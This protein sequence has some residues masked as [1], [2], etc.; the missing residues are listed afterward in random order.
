MK[1]CYVDILAAKTAR[2][3]E[4]N[5]GGM[6][7][8]EPIA[9]SGR[10]PAWELAA[11]IDFQGQGGQ[12]EDIKG[13]LICGSECREDLEPLLKSVCARLGCGEELLAT[14]QG[15]ANILSEFLNIAIGVAGADWEK[16]GFAMDFSPPVNLSGQPPQISDEAEVFQLL[17][18]GDN[19]L[20]LKLLAAFH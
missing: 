14:P 15:P 2:L 8:V 4:E 20:R 1:K 12:G 9:V 7:R 5:S 18:S 13:C 10:F 3:L 19:G 6:C 11:Q 16:Q 17:F